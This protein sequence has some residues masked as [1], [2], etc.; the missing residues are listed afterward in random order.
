MGSQRVRHDWATELNWTDTYQNQNNSQVSINIPEP[1]PKLQNL[2]LACLLHVSSPNIP[3]PPC[4]NV[5]CLKPA[6]LLH[7]ISPSRQ[8]HFSPSY[9]GHTI[10]I[11]WPFLIYL[12]FLSYAW[13]CG[14]SPQRCPLSMVN[15]C[16]SHVLSILPLGNYP[17]PIWGEAVKHRSYPILTQKQAY[18]PG[19]SRYLIPLANAIDQKGQLMLQVEP[20]RVPVLKFIINIYNQLYIINGI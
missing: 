14:C 5:L 11:F 3:T 15:L 2:I 20:I 6:F 16:C 13:F 1:S 8:T 17:L 12:L 18:D 9:W 7:S 19:H 10:V 4:P